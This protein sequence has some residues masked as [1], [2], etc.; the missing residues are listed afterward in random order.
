[1]N[2]N[3]RLRRA[4]DG[5]RNRRIQVLA[6]AIQEILGESHPEALEVATEVLQMID[7]GGAEEMLANR[8][9]A[10][11][12]ETERRQMEEMNQRLRASGLFSQ[13]EH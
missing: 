8:D 6:A 4:E 11:Y 10:S 1:M 13:Y 5:V 2:L 12:T 9:E 3:G 7:S